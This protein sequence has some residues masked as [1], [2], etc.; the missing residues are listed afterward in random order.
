MPVLPF[1]FLFT[2]WWSTLAVAGAA[3]SVP[4]IIHLLNRR[5]FRVVTWAAMRF[6]L[7][8]Q[9][10]NVRRM[11]LEQIILLAVRTL[12]VLLVVLAMASVTG[13]AEGLWKWMGLKG[14]GQRSAVHGRTHKI[15][16]VDG[17]F[18]MA[19]KK[20]TAKKKDAQ[21]CF[22]RA[23]DKAIEIVNSSGRGDSY[24]VILMT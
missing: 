3:A 11:R 4:I 15:I 17:S 21:T 12:L 24:S 8:A 2:T 5:R 18:S 23:R 10:Q 16:V 19:V 20:K 13:W 1:A 14:S 6:L 7:A 9:K 22:E